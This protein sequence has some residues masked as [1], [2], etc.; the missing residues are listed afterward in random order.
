MAKMT[1]V[2]VRMNILKGRTRGGRADSKG[3]K[4]RRAKVS[5]VERGPPTLSSLKTH[6]DVYPRAVAA[7]VLLD[8]P[9]KRS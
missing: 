6:S 7:M 3:R 4:G 8:H 1:A 2:Y 9:K 5:F